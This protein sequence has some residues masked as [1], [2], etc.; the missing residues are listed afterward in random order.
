MKSQVLPRSHER[1][2]EIARKNIVPL[3]GQAKLSRLNALQISQ[4][5]MKALESGRRDGKG[6]LSPRTVHHMHRVLKQALK[7]AVEWR[8]LTHNPAD[9]VRPPKVD[10]KPMATYDLTQTAAL[11]EWLRPTRMFI[12]AL[13]GVLCGLRRGEIVALRWDDV[14]WG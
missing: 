10:R 7:K 14:R 13:L 4:A 8:K 1:Y 12:P 9:A 3:L 11:M 2:V 6:G 5:Y